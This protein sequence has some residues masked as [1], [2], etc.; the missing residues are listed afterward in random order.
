M[1]RVR[2]ALRRQLHF[3]RLISVRIV[4]GKQM[5]MSRKG[6]SDGSWHGLI[7]CAAPAFFAARQSLS[8]GARCNI[9][10]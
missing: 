8:D 4:D 7:S 2:R 3:I 9:A 5:S 6:L 1:I 10:A